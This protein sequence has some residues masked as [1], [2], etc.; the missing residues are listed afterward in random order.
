MRTGIPWVEEVVMYFLAIAPLLAQMPSAQRTHM[1]GRKAACKD[2]CG[3]K[4]DHLE[5]KPKR[6]TWGPYKPP[7]VRASRDLRYKH[8][9]EDRYF[10]RESNSNRGRVEHLNEERRKIA[11]RMRQPL[12]MSPPQSA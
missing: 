3:L 11:T 4:R 8:T 6:G 1:L 12:R 7:P 2:V 9:K 10:G 5:A